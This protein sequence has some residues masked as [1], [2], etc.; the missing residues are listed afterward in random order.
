L[1]L[2]QGREYISKVLDIFAKR[3]CP[4]IEKYDLS[5]RWSIMQAEY[6]TD[7]VFRK[8]ADLKPLYDNLVRTAIHSVKGE[9]NINGI[10]NQYI[11]QHLPWNSGKVSR[12]LKRLRVHGLIKK[13]GGTLLSDEF[14]HLRVPNHCFQWLILLCH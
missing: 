9:L 11:R 4:V 6:A 3:Y 1:N 2:K 12:M 8:Q 14:I 13:V 5:Y 10:R 7:I